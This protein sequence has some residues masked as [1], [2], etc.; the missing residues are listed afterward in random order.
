M[1]CFLDPVHTGQYN[2]VE[3]AIVSCGRQDGA[4]VFLKTPDQDVQVPIVKDIYNCSGVITL[5][6]ASML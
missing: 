5:N 1:Q 2:Q 4:P 3:R 6:C